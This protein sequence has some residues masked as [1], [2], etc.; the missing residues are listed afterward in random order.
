MTLPA[1]KQFHSYGSL[2]HKIDAGIKYLLTG[3][4]VIKDQIAVFENI[5]C[6]NFQDSLPYSNITVVLRK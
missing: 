3:F 1:A 5:Y 6:R 2:S 4:T